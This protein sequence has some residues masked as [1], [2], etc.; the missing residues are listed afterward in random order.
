M[1]TVKQNKDI[2]HNSTERDKMEEPDNKKQRIEDNDKEQTTKTN[3]QPSRIEQL[4]NWLKCTNCSKQRQITPCYN[5]TND[6]LLC[7]RCY[8]MELMKSIGNVKPTCSICKNE[9]IKSDDSI[10]KIIPIITENLTL[11]FKR[12][13]GSSNRVVNRRQRMLKHPGAYKIV[14]IVKRRY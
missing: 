11:P 9:L 10:N 14:N 6:H 1:S 3:N 13:Q 4:R 7:N 5:C 2:T 12:R 8:N